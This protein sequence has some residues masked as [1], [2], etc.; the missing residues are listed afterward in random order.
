MPR[1]WAT[2]GTPPTSTIAKRTRNSVIVSLKD[3]KHPRP[4]KE[5]WPMPPMTNFSHKREKGR[6]SETYFPSGFRIFT[7]SAWTNSLPQIR[8]PVLSGSSSPSKPLT[9]PPASRIMICP[10]AMSQG[11]RLRSQ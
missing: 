6:D 4:V 1:T 7:S 9:V 10:A 11:D 2:S 3:A 5:R 8:W